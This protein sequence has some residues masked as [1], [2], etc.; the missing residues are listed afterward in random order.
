MKHFDVEQQSP[1]RINFILGDIRHGFASDLHKI[2]ILSEAEIFGEQ[3]FKRARVVTQENM[4][5]SLSELNV[6]DPV[7]HIDH[8]IGLYH[9]LQKMT[10]AGVE[11][12][13]LVFQYLK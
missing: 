9:G 4:L 10:D 12:D 7:V 6:S 3:K 11:F 8:G 13:F 5:E 1:F 2:A